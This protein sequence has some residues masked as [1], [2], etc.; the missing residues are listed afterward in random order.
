[1]RGRLRVACEA[2]DCEITEVAHAPQQWYHSE[3]VI[4]N[5][6]LGKTLAMKKRPDAP[7]QVLLGIHM[8]TV[9]SPESAFQTTTLL[10]PKTLRG[11]GVADAKGGLVVMLKALEA[12]ERSPFTESLGWE[13]FINADEEVGSPGSA[14]YL[15]DRAQGRH[16]GLVFEPTL[17]DGSL[18]GSR[19]GSGMFTLFVKGRAAH[20]GRSYDEGR[21][22]IDALAEWIVQLNVWQKAH[23]DIIVNVGR[24]DGGAQVNIVPEAALCRFNVRVSSED[25][26]TR[27]EEKLQALTRRANEQDGITAHLHGAFAR[28]PKPL[29]GASL[30]LMKHI[31]VCGRDL[32]LAIQWHDPGGVS[33]GNVLAAAGLPTI[34][35]LGVRGG[36]IH[37]AEEFIHLESLTE[38]TRLTSLLLMKLAT[39]DIP[40]VLRPDSES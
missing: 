35:T 21:N 23:D 14:S 24:I 7:L 29:Q 19:K 2:L 16:L 9:F 39:G 34:D 5:R 22:A 12:F 15:T 8:D 32:G 25:D 40:W 27:V 1:M 33:D 13:V 6:Q 10:D 3:D 11:P 30:R 28:P 18:A 20:V 37:T 17:P 26:Q 4:E 38:R 31:A 36:N